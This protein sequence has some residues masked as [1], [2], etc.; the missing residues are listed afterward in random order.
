MTFDEAKNLKLGDII[1]HVNFK[2]VK[3]TQER[4]RVSGKVK[5][6]KRD[7]TRIRIPIKYG[8]FSNGY[9]DEKSL[10]LFDVK[11]KIKEKDNV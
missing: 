10:I 1:Y 5:L 8:L 6:W 3:G 7:P 4:W 2:N 11:E 9:L